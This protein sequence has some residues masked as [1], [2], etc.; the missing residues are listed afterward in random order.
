MLTSQNITGYFVAIEDFNLT[1]EN[2]THIDEGDGD[3]KVENSQIIM[4]LAIGM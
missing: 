3:D 2:I 4:Y 1:T